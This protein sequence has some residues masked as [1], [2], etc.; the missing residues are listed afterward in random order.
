MYAFFKEDLKVPYH[1][2]VNAID[3]PLFNAVDYKPIARPYKNNPRFGSVIHME[4]QETGYED[5]SDREIITAALEKLARVPV[6]ER[7]R[8]ATLVHSWLYRCNRNHSRIL[9]TD[10]GTYKFRPKVVSP[11]R[12]L[13]MAGDWIQH[14]VVLPCMEG[15]V[16][17]GIESAKRI[18]ADCGIKDRKG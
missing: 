4:G 17:T 3:P 16:R 6:F 10:P 13:F 14:D 9:L 2:Q 11:F 12:N 15:A 18:L 1:V 7:I 8:N 5:L